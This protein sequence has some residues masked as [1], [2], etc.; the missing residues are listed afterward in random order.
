M[1]KDITTESYSI[2]AKVSECTL[3]RTEDS[4]NGFQSRSKVTDSIY[5]INSGY[6]LNWIDKK[7]YI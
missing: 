3:A 5:S 1:R 2:V 4:L 6:L 7:Q